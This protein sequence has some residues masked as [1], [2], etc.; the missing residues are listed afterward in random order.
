MNADDIGTGVLA[1]MREGNLSDEDPMDSLGSR[2][3]KGRFKGF[4]NNYLEFWDKLLRDSSETD[5]LFSAGNMVKGEENKDSRKANDSSSSPLFDSLSDLVAMFS[6]L[7]ARKI[8]VAATEAGL[9]LVTSLVHIAKVK[10]DTRDLKQRQLDAEGKKKRPNVSMMK[11]LNEGL[12]LTQ[13]RIR[14]VESMIKDS[15]NKIFTHRF[16]DI[17]PAIRSIC[18]RSIGSWMREHPLFFLTDFYLKYLGWSLHDKDP[19]V[20]LT[21]LV[22]LRQ[23]YGTSYENLALMDTFTARFIWRVRE[24]VNDVDPSVAAEVV[25]TL[26]VLHAAGVLPR[27]D[28]EPVVSL[29]LDGDEQ[30]RTAAAAV[31][32]SLMTNSKEIIDIDHIAGYD[33]SLA[34][35]N[36]N[37]SSVGD[38]NG[39]G[40]HST[41]LFIV[42][43][44]KGLHGSRARTASTVDAIWYIYHLQLSDWNLFVPCSFQKTQTPI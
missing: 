40:S 15:F 7:R 35:I 16:R 9:Q 22:I 38:D 41:L 25:G 42:H 44:I 43:I 5:E 17:D 33:V 4:R 37:E 6:G 31:I 23:L 11:T 32:P 18:M 14:S 13:A 39:D 12:A 28:M 19:R 29:L 3:S 10:A 26:A 27:K 1:D 36:A 2:G 34:R 20:R 8:R 30:I 24:M 21:V